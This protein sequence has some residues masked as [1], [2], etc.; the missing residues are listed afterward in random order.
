MVDNR[1]LIDNTYDTLDSLAFHKSK[2]IN[3]NSLEIY[4]IGNA[5]TAH[6]FLL[7]IFD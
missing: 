7:V 3:D 4:I 5:A 6:K 2:E 1:H